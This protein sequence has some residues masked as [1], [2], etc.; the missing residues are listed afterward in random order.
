MP[1]TLPLHCLCFHEV[2]SSHVG[3]S[4][5]SCRQYLEKIDGALSKR[6]NTAPQS[7]SEPPIP[8]IINK[9]PA[10]PRKGMVSK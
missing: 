1:P 6:I 8:T 5:D 10:K 4:A 9:L 3:M 2:R 7:T